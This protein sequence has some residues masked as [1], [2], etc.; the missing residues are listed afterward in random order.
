[1]TFIRFES[2]HLGHTIEGDSSTLRPGGADPA[3]HGAFPGRVV[4]LGPEHDL[5]LLLG[6]AQVLPHGL[7]DAQP[8]HR[9]QFKHHYPGP[10]D[11]WPPVP[12]APGRLP[13]VA[14]LAAVDP[15][16]VVVLQ[17]EEADQTG[18]VRCW[19]PLPGPH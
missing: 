16:Q 19:P 18:D 14:G 2:S 4:G 11:F 5:S 12:L 13:I 3:D 6:P 7:T 1:M 9:A 17:T 10:P 15:P 8:A